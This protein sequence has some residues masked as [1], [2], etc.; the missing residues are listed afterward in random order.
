MATDFLDITRQCPIVEGTN[1]ELH[2]ARCRSNPS[3]Q[4]EKRQ[5][6]L[7]TT[8]L[9]ALPEILIS[10]PH[11]QISQYHL[12]QPHDLVLCVIKL[13]H[14]SRF[15]FKIHSLPKNVP[16]PLTPPPPSPQHI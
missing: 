6:P 3:T 15:G 8:M 2:L 9:I 13:I 4:F 7:P 5:Q 10:H 1:L 12:Q 11:A 16:P 14:L